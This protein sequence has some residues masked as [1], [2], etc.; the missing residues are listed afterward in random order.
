[1]LAMARGRLST[2]YKKA[3]LTK[4][5]KQCLS[6][7]ANGLHRNQ[8]SETLGVA[9]STVDFHLANAKK[10]LSAKTR[11]QALARAIVL[12]FISLDA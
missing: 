4:R 8:I 1:M 2:V 6:L 9:V 10:K 12:K 3:R 11:E 7:L 5:E